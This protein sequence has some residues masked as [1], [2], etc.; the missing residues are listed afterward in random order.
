MH[1]CNIDAVRAPWLDTLAGF[2]DVI[3]LRVAARQTCGVR[4][5]VS[6]TSIYGPT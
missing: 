4:A 2:D 1:G 3:A 6:A 5:D